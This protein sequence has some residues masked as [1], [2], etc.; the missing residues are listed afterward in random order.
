MKVATNR[1][2]H[3]PQIESPAGSL[4]TTILRRLTHLRRRGSTFSEIPGPYPVCHR[5][6][7]PLGVYISTSSYMRSSYHHSTES[8]GRGSVSFLDR[9]L[10][11]REAKN[12]IR[13]RRREVD[14]DYN[15]SPRFTKNLRRLFLFATF[16][17]TL[18]DL[19]GSLV[20]LTSTLFKA[21]W[22]NLQVCL[23]KFQ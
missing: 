1:V 16:L 14:E 18:A 6:A 20:I 9:Q 23:C 4:C 2:I 21:R 19:S 10:A 17:L 7:L 3:V 12:R 15:R 11:L 22:L 5:I 8:A 13:Q